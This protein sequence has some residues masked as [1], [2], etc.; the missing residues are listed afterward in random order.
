MKMPLRHL[1]ITYEDFCRRAR[2]ARCTALSVCYRPCE[3]EIATVFSTS[4]AELLSDKTYSVRSSNRA[5]TS[6]TNYDDPN[7]R[8][9]RF[10]ELM[11]AAPL[12][13]QILDEGAGS[14]GQQL[15]ETTVISLRCSGCSRRIIIDGLHRLSRLAA[16]RRTEAIVH[17]V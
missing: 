6:F 9:L 13:K 12:L 14:A 7:A 8:A 1:Q 3:D 17:V 11:V 5:R 10:D 4:V 15:T 2:D 16:E